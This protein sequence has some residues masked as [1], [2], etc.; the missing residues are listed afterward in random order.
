ML[1]FFEVEVNNAAKNSISCTRLFAFTGET[2][3]CCN[4]NDP[5][6]GEHI[7]TWN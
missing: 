3:F 6:T 4:I 5:E 7:L 2:T 1:A